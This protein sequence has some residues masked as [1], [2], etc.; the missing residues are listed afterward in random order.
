[1]SRRKQVSS[2][3]F[4]GKTLLVSG[5]AQGLSEMIRRRFHDEGANVVAIDG[6]KLHAW[7]DI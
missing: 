7:D 1:M 6:G 4:A 5:A 2:E 3:R